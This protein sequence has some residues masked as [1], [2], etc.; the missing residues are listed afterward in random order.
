MKAGVLIT[1]A[2]TFA[3]TA[4]VSVGGIQAMIPE[5]HRQAVDVYGWM[6]DAEFATTFAIS[7]I[8][9]GPNILIMSLMGWR[10]AGFAGLV[11]ATLATVGPTCLV[12]L[13]AH[14]AEKRLLHAHWYAVSRRSL[15]PIIV[16]LIVASALVTAQAA[17]TAPFGIVIAF[18][19][20]LYIA[21]TKTNP[22]IPLFVAIV[23]GIVAGRL[24]Y[25]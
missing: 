8:A 6:D 9:P 13:F 5:I 3:T 10:I 16:G 22:L 12:A 17:I 19:V 23:C 18:G 7:Q 25:L 4:I 1:M 2:V 20:A 15:P 21:F 14:R 24:G 11:V